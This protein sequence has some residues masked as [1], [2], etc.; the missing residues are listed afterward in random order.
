MKVEQIIES[1]NNF[2]EK[3]EFHYE[4]DETILRYDYGFRLDGVINRAGCNLVVDADGDG[5]IITA[6]PEIG[7]PEKT[8]G[9]LEH[10]LFKMNCNMLRG[11][12]QIDDNEIRY[13]KNISLEGD[14]AVLTYEML[15]AC[16][17]ASATVIEHYADS[18]V[19]VIAGAST[20]DEEIKK[21][22][23]DEGDSEKEDAEED[24]DNDKD[25]SREE[26]ANSVF[27]WL[28]GGDQ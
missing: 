22:F 4:F 23:E 12:W 26:T 5:C 27:L 9:E 3:E 19:A 25:L 2:F 20:A 13:V 1:I 21:L 17:Y 15:D 16:I 11:T 10:L 6:Y 7:I 14:S 24:E 28:N 8:M 18:I